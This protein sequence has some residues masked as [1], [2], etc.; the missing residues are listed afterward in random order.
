MHLPQDV[1]GTEGQRGDNCLK[2]KN[3][4]E[5]EWRRQNE[6]GMKREERGE[7]RDKEGEREK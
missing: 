2:S 3:Q 5:R 1:R 4:K 7:E 6:G